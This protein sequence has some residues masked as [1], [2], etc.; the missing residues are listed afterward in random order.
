MPKE[1]PLNGHDYT[2]SLYHD[3]GKAS[4]FTTFIKN[5]G[6]QIPSTSVFR[7]VEYCEHQLKAM[8]TGKDGDLI[9]NE[10]NLKKKM[11]VKVCHHFVLD[12]TIELFPDQGHSDTE[13]LVEE[14]HITKLIK[15]IADKYFTLRL[16]KFGKKYIQEVEN[17][18][19]PSDRHRLNKLILFNNQ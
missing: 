1:I 10:C 9:S 3:I 13:I 4:A 12:S 6:L 14:D 17:D 15:F 2:A 18:G 7:T 19:K 5:G 11:I 16:F 8:V